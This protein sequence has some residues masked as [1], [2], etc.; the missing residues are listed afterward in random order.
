VRRL[1]DGTCAGGHLRG[2][3]HRLRVSIYID[4][5]AIALLQRL[6]CP[7][8]CQRPE[9]FA[10]ARPN[11]VNAFCAPTPTRSRC[12]RRASSAGVVITCGGGDAKKKNGKGKK[13]RKVVASD[14]DDK[15]VVTLTKGALKRA[16]RS[17]VT[18]A[19]EELLASL[20]EEEEDDGGERR[21]EVEVTYVK[22]CAALPA[23]FSSVRRN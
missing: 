13:E 21:R 2:P 5:D 11:C 15:V 8:P 16:I 3:A 17:G 22:V 18:V 14:E 6:V 9:M 20:E 23:L 10:F 4:F 19:L 7:R 12:T 1:A